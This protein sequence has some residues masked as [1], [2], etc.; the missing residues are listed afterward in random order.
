MTCLGTVR[1]GVVVLDTAAPFEDGTRV[2]VEADM[3]PSEPPR[4]SAQAIL[5]AD[6]KWVG[7][8]DELDRL[9][10]EVQK[11]RDEDVELQRRQGRF[12]YSPR[13]RTD[14]RG[15]ADAAIVE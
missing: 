14:H 11:M 7:Q 1:N 10:A 2:R 12:G 9:L 6:V 8:R 5:D 4:G 13:R 15:L 3:A